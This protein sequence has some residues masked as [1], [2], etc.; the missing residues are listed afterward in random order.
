[1]KLKIN[2]ACDLNSISVLP[3]HTRRSSGI[4]G[5]PANSVLGSGQPSQLRSQ[6]SQQ[7]FSQA[8]SSQHGML[9]QLSQN[10]LD[11]VVTHDQRFG[12]QEKDNSGKRIYCLAPV[13]Y[14][15]ESQVPISRSS[16]NLMRKWSSTSLS[17]QI[18]E[19]LEHKIAMIETSLSRFGMILDS[20][21]SDVM[22]VNRGTKELS[23]ELD[24]IRQKLI[25]HEDF[26]HSLNR[27]QDDIKASL[28][29]DFKSIKDQLSKN[30]HQDKLQETLSV[31]LTLPEHVEAC[32]Q[33]LKNELWRAF[34]RE[35]Q[36]NIC[37]V[38]TLNH[39]NLVPAVLPSKV[40]SDSSSK[41]PLLK[42]GAMP[43]T[44]LKEAPL[45]PKIEMGSWNTVKVEKAAL[46]KR[47]P[48]K[49]ER[50]KGVSSTEQDGE[51]RGLIDLDENTDGDFSCLAI[52][53]REFHLIN[54]A[55]QETE[56]ILRKARRRK[57]KQ[58]NTIN[59][60]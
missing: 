46:P 30:V 13:P 27:G 2:K 40:C 59:I 55:K 29:T 20:V 10:S 48:F 31:L 16:S 52:E 54:E 25:V 53:E 8:V 45:V 58:C 56:R 6:A 51:L 18:S 49:E 26:L 15:E 41:I 24:S 22:Q 11:D 36:A 32:L 17:G 14:R 12:S 42:S 19:E 23:L 9:S 34:S 7:S 1:M 60:N 38:K 39:N 4:H 57:R 50:R 37:N 47:N 33:N 43:P 5:G 28:D 21:Q 3:P 44:V 35:L